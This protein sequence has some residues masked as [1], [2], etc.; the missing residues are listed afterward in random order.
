M[1]SAKTV[2]SFLILLVAVGI[3]LLFQTYQGILTAAGM[4]GLFVT[5]AIVA[6]CF[7]ITLL[8]L[9][10]KSTHQEIRVSKAKQPAV[11]TKSATKKVA[12]AKRKKSR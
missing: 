9:V 12:P 3:F 7:L 4:L 2:A 1:D 10:S 6:G 11:K 5:L 8:Y